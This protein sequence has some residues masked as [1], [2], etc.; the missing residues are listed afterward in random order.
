M[1]RRLVR[2]SDVQQQRL[3]SVWAGYLA[4]G[5]VTDVSGDPGK[6][7]SRLTYD[8]G[9]RITTGQPM[10]GCTD[11]SDP[12]GV[13]LLQG[14][15]AVDKTVKPA[16]AAAGADLRRIYVYD[17]REFGSSPLRLPDDLPLIEEAVLDV[18]AKLLIIDPATQF[19]TCNA[20]SEMSVRQALKRVSDFA[21][22]HSLAVLIIR[23][24]NKTNSGNPLYQAGGS[25]AWIAAARA[26]FRAVDDA[27]SNDPHRH[28][29][30][31]IKN[32][33]A[34]APTLAYR[35]VLGSTGEITV[36]WLGQANVSV[37][38]L[39]RGDRVETSKLWEAMEV[40]YLILRN[41]P[42]GAKYVVEKARLEQV[43]K[44]TLERAKRVL[45]VKPER[46]QGRWD[47]QWN[48][49]LPDEE[50]PVL[51][52][53]RDKYAALDAAAQETVEAGPVAES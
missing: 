10:P 13:V 1:T 6:A 48:W 53:L 12:A 44:R 38:D 5:A 29:L 32:N 51:R 20:N 35:T 17:H 50:T 25:I 14:E 11:A 37:K 23:H 43:A 21:E 39:S 27:T 42:M 16:L 3:K 40:L 24:L 46:E 22:T 8:I 9:A 47:W 52:Y 4:E 34:S 26:A 41:G 33:L 30:V 19:F 15:D 45:D 36:D 31:E 2:L 49:R 28:V 7:K 18:G